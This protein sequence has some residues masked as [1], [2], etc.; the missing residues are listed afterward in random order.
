MFDRAR[1][2]ALAMADPTRVGLAARDP[3]TVNTLHFQ[4]DNLVLA[5]IAVEFSTALNGTW[6]AATSGNFAGI[7]PQTAKY[8]RCTYNDANNALFFVPIL[9]AIVPGVATTMSVGATAAAAMLPS[10]SSC[11]FPVAVCTSAGGTAANNYNHTIGERLT[12]VNTPSSGY[13][14]GNFGWLDFTPPAGG[15]SELATLIEGTGSCA[16]T[17]SATVGEAGVV[18]SLEAAWN[19]RFGVYHPSKSFTAARPDVTGYSYPTG[20]NHYADF[21]TQS[22]ARAPF[23]GT[24]GG[25]S[26]KLTSAQHGVEGRQ[27]RRVLTAAVVDCAVWAGGGNPAVLDFACILMLAPVVNGGG[28]SSWSDV[29]P[30]MDIEFLGL[31]RQVGTPCA[32]SGLGGGA[33]GPP[34]PTLVQ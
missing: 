24:V 29:A 1:S 30:T 19:T 10:Q 21:E 28:P 15:A 6:V 5:N 9:G 23:Q 16:V 32:T 3:I 26:T 7:T 14:T 20:S 2:N 13:G 31:T 34:V 12:A 4:R 17:P 11:A 33:F 27:N 25:G 18:T 8:V 22:A